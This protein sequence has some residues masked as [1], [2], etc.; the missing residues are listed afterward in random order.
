ML[1]RFADMA[2]GEGREELGIVR[3]TRRSRMVLAVAAVAVTAAACGSSGSSG[4]GP[5][6][7]SGGSGASGSTGAKAT[8][9]YTVGLLVD[10]TGIAASGQKHVEDGMKAAISIVAKQGY[11]IKYVVADTQSS[12]AGA[13]S[14]AQSLVQRQHVFA[15]IAHSALFFAAAP[16]LTKQNI[17]VIGAPQDGPEWITSKNMFATYGAI[18]TEKV[19]TTGGL[20][21]KQQGVTNLGSVGYSISPSSAEASKT[22]ALSAQAVGLKAGYVNSKFPFGSTD[23]QPIALAMKDAGIDAVTPEVDPNTSFALITA[24]RNAGVDLKVALLPIGYGVDLLQAGPGTLKAAQNVYFSLTYEPV[25]LHTKATEAFVAALKATGGTTAP[26]LPTYDGYASILMLV[27]GLQG[28]GAN[29]TQASVIASLSKIHDF[30]PGGLYGSH[31]LDINDRV[32]L[33]SGPDGCE[34]FVKLTGSTFE[35]VKNA[36]PLCGTLVPGKTV[37]P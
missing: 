2:V 8:K 21:L 6:G 13:L 19:A 31:P 15:V 3:Q 36:D 4:S 34:Y 22:S 20:F 12:P 11:N 33:V 28:A 16:Y 37:T 24:L 27:Q 9:T 18:H 14:A 1:R 29:P 26:G 10:D 5:T 25:E 32:N 23:V 7:G 35:P 30:N 17:P